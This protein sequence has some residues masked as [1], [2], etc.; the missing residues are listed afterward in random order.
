MLPRR[1]AEARNWKRKQKPET[2][3]KRHALL[4][5]LGRRMDDAELLRIVGVE[6]TVSVVLVTTI[7]AQELRRYSELPKLNGIVLHNVALHELGEFFRQAGLSMV[8]RNLRLT[9]SIQ[10]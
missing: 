1:V 5:I 4:I 8:G 10:H 7:Q 3:N 6:I 9:L 2:E